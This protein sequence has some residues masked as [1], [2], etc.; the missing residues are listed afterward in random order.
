MQSNPNRSNMMSA[1]LGKDLYKEE[2]KL[3]VD[4]S[5]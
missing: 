2:H 4:C 3:H 5:M 1:K